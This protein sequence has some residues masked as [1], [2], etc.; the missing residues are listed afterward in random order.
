MNFVIGSMRRPVTAHDCK[1]RAD[2]VDG[3]TRGSLMSGPG[4]L[5]KAELRKLHKKWAVCKHI[6][7]SLDDAFSNIIQRRMIE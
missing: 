6:S 1:S 2:A 5:V 3:Y 7:G 4:Q